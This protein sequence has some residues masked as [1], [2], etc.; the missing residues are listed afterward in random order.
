MAPDEAKDNVIQQ[1][2]GPPKSQAASNH[3]LSLD[4]CRGLA[5]FVVMFYHINFLLF[6]ELKI[7]Q[8]GYLCVDFFFILSGYVIANSYDARVASGLSVRHFLI[9]RMARL[10]PLVLLT[11]LIAFGV[12]TIRLRRDIPDISN[13]DL[14]VTLVANSLMMPSPRS[15]NEV[16][17]PF[18]GSAWSIF[19]EMVANLAY[20]AAF[21]YLSRGILA[22]VIACSGL[23][24]AW[25]ALF[26]NSLDVGMTQE[27]FVFGFPRVFFS[28][29]LGV[30]LFRRRDNFHF[31]TSSSF[32]SLGLFAA[33]ALICLP[34]FLFTRLDGAIDLAIVVC[35]F[36]IILLIAERTK[37]SG[38]LSAFAWFFGG[39]S[40][41]VY[42]LQTP[43][44]I[45]YSALP[46]I[47]F[48]AKVSAFVPWA[49]M[50]FILFIIQVS[51]L[52]WV[53]FERPA[54]RWLTKRLLNNEGRLAGFQR[55]HQ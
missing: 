35:F 40:Y 43:L 7:F 52:C 30:M 50:V 14:I 18:N 10:W 29:F 6:E 16:L 24:L 28:F 46:Q 42:L 21:R 34:K 9:I 41:S 26:F 38:R 27:N 11:T 1:M 2:T 15:P 12:Q 47:F 22:L 45:A 48:G 20:V 54:Q 53:F 51:Y 4:L 25:T 5:A 19:F 39:I 13:L 8:R 36:P 17:F 23:A 3:I 37:L 55:P 44:M 32:L 31:L 33:G 49:G